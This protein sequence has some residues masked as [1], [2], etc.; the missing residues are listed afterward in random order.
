MIHKPL[1]P[2]VIKQAHM[3][4]KPYIHRTPLLESH[5]LNRWLGHELVFKVEGLQKI[6]AFKIRGAL[7]A[8]LALKETGNLPKKVVAFSSGNHAQA[9]AMASGL[10]GIP[11]TIFMT[12]SVSK[13]KQQ[14]TTYYGATVINT[15]NRQEAE[16]HTA[17]LA[18]QGA[19]FIHPFDNDMVIAGQG[20]ACYEA[21][22]DGANP[23]AIFATCGGGGWLSGTYLAAQLL[24][25][26]VKVFAGEPLQANDAAQ[27]Y[28]NGHI[29]RFETSPNT[30]ADGA[31]TMAVSERTFHYLKQLDGFFEV[32]EEEIL[33]WTQWI[34]HLLKVS[35]EP[36]SAV[37]MGA[38]FKWLQSQTQKQ[39]VLVMLSGGNIAPEAYRKIWERSYLEN[40]LEPPGLVN[41]GR[42]HQ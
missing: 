34:M 6:G 7:N 35:V 17:E 39:R 42:V 24:A 16:A 9:V 20:T 23:T 27:S 30:I 32:S 4:I 19:Y 36:T 21:L 3:R 28:R 38:A 31:Q 12:S 1:P 8:L 11:S 26:G 37:A 10:F 14:A 2:E 18:G 15:A 22:Q 40:M 5:L 41:K 25:P 33:Y 13:I 29:F